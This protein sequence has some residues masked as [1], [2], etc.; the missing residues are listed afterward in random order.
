QQTIIHHEIDWV[1][2]T[3]EISSQLILHEPTILG[4]AR[5]PF[6]PLPQ[7][8]ALADKW[9]LVQLADKA[10][11]AYPRTVHFATGATLLPDIINALTYPIVVKPTQSRRW[12]GDRWLSTSV[13]IA[14]SAAELNTLLQQKD[15]LRDH[16]FM[17]QEFISGHGAGVFALYEH[18]KPITFFSHQRLREKP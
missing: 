3:T 8:M 16:P 17:L 18:G 13:H 12:L 1:F 11:L 10:G 15:Y 7:V 6:A 9:E 2:P 14:H 5:I 4:R